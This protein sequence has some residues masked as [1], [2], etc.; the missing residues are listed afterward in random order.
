VEHAA[1]S[2]RKQLR[3]KIQI[4]RERCK[5][6]CYCVNACE[7]GLIVIGQE[8]NR[9]GYFPASFSDDGQCTGCSMCG[10]VCPEVAIEVWR[11][12]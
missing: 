1:T 12:D 6:C 2:T 3:G 8:L 11:E 7:K 10:W 9:L 5:G 4:D